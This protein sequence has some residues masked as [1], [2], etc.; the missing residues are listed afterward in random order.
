MS[1]QWIECLPSIREVIEDFDIAVIFILFIIYYKDF[2]IV[3]PSRKQ[4]LCHT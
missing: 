1:S 3:V 4:D 2:D